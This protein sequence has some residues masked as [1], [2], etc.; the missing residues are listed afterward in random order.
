MHNVDRT[1]SR[2]EFIVNKTKP[3]AYIQNQTTNGREVLHKKNVEHFSPTPLE[4]RISNH[5]SLC[6]E[7]LLSITFLITY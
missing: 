5:D 2:T 4:Y 6:Y 3:H 7:R 1:H